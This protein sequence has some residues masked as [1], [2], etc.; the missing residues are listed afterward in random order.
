M[1]RFTVRQISTGA[2][3]N[4]NP[5]ANQDEITDAKHILGWI[6]YGATAALRM[7]LAEQLGIPLKVFDGI[8]QHAYSQIWD[9]VGGA[10]WTPPRP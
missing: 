7:A 5:W 1:A 4:I 6:R 9:D 3:L 10:P 2:Q 8:C